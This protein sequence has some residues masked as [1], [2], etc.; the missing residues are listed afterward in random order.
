MSSKSRLVASFV[1]PPTGEELNMAYAPSIVMALK[2][3][4]DNLDTS[5]PESLPYDHEKRQ[6]DDSYD[7]E[8]E[9]KAL[10]FILNMFRDL[11]VPQSALSLFHCMI[12]NGND[13]DLY[14]YV[15]TSSVKRRRFLERRKHIFLLGNA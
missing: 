1:C 9:L 14:Q 4:Q 8:R 5:K 3:L 11:G 12:S 10:N 15:G 13:T 7:V 6:C 2:E